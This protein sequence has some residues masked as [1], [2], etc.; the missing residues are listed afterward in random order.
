MDKAKILIVEDEAIIALEIESKLQSLGYEVTS[1]VDT[2]DDAIKKAEEDNPDLILMDI[3]INGELDG[4]QA[5]NQ[6]N[7]HS[8]ISIIFLTAFADE[9]NVNRAKLVLP[10]GY[11]LKPVQDRELKIAIEIALYV[12]KVDKERKKAEEGLRQYE[13][14]VSNSTDMMALLNTK[15]TYLAA[16]KSYLEAFVPKSSNVIGRT[17]TEVF[18]NEFFETVIK[19]NASRCLLG[20]NITYQEWFDFPAGRK[21][22][23]INYYPYFDSEKE[24]KGF[25]VNGRDITKQ[26]RAEVALQKTLQHLENLVEVRTI[27]LKSANERLKKEINR[28]E[29]IAKE[30]KRSEISYKIIA[31]FTYDWETWIDPDGN[32][33]YVSPS[34]ERISGYR[35]EEFTKDPDLIIKITHADDREKVA[36]HFKKAEH[37]KKLIHP[38]D[39][40]IMH[41]KGELVWISHACCSVHDPANNYLG[42]RG[43]NRNI[44]ERKKYQIELSSVRLGNCK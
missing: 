19:P 2:G 4:I 40:R 8:D 32:Y 29:V 36:D 6:I 7:S 9:D 24:I 37:L 14:I 3:R 22:M 16:N 11:L 31:D 35:P 23:E 13:H 20:N 5:A 39:F 15:F 42:R 28:N 33:I 43:S 26:K 27:D 12:T 17:V 30:L 38:I 18:G 10:F 44:T 34:C 25:I 1:I 21:F 41:K